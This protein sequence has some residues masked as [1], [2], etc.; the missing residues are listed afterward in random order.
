VN[1]AGEVTI[2]DLLRVDIDLQK[3]SMDK[4]YLDDRELS[5]KEVFIMIAYNIVAHAHAQ[6]HSLAN[7]GINPDCDDPCI[8]WMSIVTVIYN[9]FGFSIFKQCA[10]FW[11]T[12]GLL[13]YDLSIMVLECIKLGIKEG[14]QPHPG[15]RKLMPHSSLV[16][17]ISTMR[18]PFAQA[19]QAH[20]D[21]MMGIDCE[22]LF[23]NTVLHSLDHEMYVVN[24]PDVLWLDDS[25]EE[26][27]W[28]A[29]TCQMTRMGFIPE[30]PLLPFNRKFR[31]MKH[32]FYKDVYHRARGIDPWFADR[33]D[34]CIIR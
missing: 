7:W 4:A 16:H 28:M 10:R 26:L 6:I 31:N 24:I 9:Y 34:T 2:H 1:N 8:R 23:A 25:H 33:M 14:V 13:K 21:V 22:G 18:G 30:L 15:I 12:L 17:F 20:Q 11:K 19:F 5:P 29:E 3:K 27:G 32:K